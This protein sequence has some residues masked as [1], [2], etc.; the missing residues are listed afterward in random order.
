MIFSF[1][2]VST[3]A[4]L[5]TTAGEG[6]VLF[7]L[8]SGFHN[9]VPAVRSLWLRTNIISYTMSLYWFEVR[10]F[11]QR[12]TCVFYFLFLKFG[13]QIKS[14]KMM[15][16]KSLS[17]FLT[18]ILASGPISNLVIKQIFWLQDQFQ[19]GHTF[20]FYNLG[21]NKILLSYEMPYGV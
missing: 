4:L 15:A 12:G 8:M 17:T 14:I 6:H 18:D 5:G 9:W 2:G 11:K 16:F 10:D 20:L 21:L 13:Y 7:V 1:F 3:S 19:I